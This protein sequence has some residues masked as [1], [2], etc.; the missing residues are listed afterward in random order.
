MITLT[1]EQ[2]DQLEAGEELDKL[3]CEAVGIHKQECF[4]AVAADELAIVYAYPPVSTDMGAFWQV[5]GKM[6]ADD[7]T[8]HPLFFKLSHRFDYGD[9]AVTYAAYDWKLTG[10]GNPPYKAISPASHPALAGCRATL[11]V[12]RKDEDNDVA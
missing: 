2:I 9:K 10:D 7:R 1:D 5:V 4:I 12:L 11:K 8:P 6:T 3:V